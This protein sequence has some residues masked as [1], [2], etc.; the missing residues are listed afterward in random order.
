[1]V[2]FWPSRRPLKS[3]RT[4]SVT[5]RSIAA[6]DANTDE[7]PGTRACSVTARKNLS[8]PRC[9]RRGVAGDS[10]FFVVFFTGPETWEKLGLKTLRF[11]SLFRP[12]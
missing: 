11:C 2:K 4:Q 5:V 7:C 3:C 12:F 8:A 1:M 9:H 6:N 10:L